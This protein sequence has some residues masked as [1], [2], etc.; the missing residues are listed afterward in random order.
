M[1]SGSGHRLTVDINNAVQVHVDDMM[2]T[3]ILANLIT[4]TTDADIKTVLTKYNPTLSVDRIYRDLYDCKANILKKAAQFLNLGKAV[5]LNKSDIANYII[6]KIEN[7]LPET[8]SMC[9]DTY[10]ME[11]GSKPI[12]QCLLCSQGI[13][14]QCLREKN[15][16]EK[17]PDIKGLVWLCPHCEPRATLGVSKIVRKHRETRMSEVVSQQNT[18]TT[19]D[20]ETGQQEEDHNV[21][22]NHDEKNTSRTENISDDPVNKTP[23]KVCIHYRNNRC[24]HGISGKNCSFMHPKPCKKL[25][26][27]GDKHKLGCKKAQKCIFFHPKM[28][29]DSLSKN[30]CLNENCKCLHVKGTRRTKTQNSTVMQTQQTPTMEYM[31]A[32]P[33]ASGVQENTNTTENSFLDL[34]QK[35]QNRLQFIESAQQGQYSL[36]QNLM[37]Q[38]QTNTYQVAA[39]QPATYQMATAQPTTYQV[40]TSTNQPQVTTAWTGQQYTRQT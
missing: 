5:S 24:R 18:Q 32:P 13:H 1:A 9:K 20:T 28:C 33:V 40:A 22:Q 6:T 2:A 30:E 36:I 11:F 4:I 37:N 17:L 8:C 16:Q 21:E 7:L 34:L 29:R 39:T 38:T 23:A 15:K 10:C 31:L 14:E 26:T 25:L 27:H 3:E 35:I 12:L 19:D